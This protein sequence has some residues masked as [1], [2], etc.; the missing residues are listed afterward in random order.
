MCSTGFIPSGV[1][2]IGINFQCGMHGC[3]A[4]KKWTLDAII[5]GA[6]CDSKVLVIKTHSKMNVH[7]HPQRILSE[8]YHKPTLPY[9][10]FKPHLVYKDKRWSQDVS[11][12]GKRVDFSKL[13]KDIVD[14][15]PNHL[16]RLPDCN[17]SSRE[18]DMQDAA[19]TGS[20]TDVP[21]G[22]GMLLGGVGARLVE[23]QLSSS[24]VSMP[25]F[26][27]SRAI[28]ER[29]L[30][31]NSAVENA[32]RPWRNDGDETILEELQ[33]L[34]KFC[35]KEYKVLLTEEMQALYKALD[36]KCHFIQKAGFLDNTGHTYVLLVDM[37]SLMQFL[38]DGS[39]VLLSVRKQ[40][41]RHFAFLFIQLMLI[42]LTSSSTGFNNDGNEYSF[43]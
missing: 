11:N 24:V 43:C 3:F 4:K 21:K 6:D 42:S 8:H 12:V 25:T 41:T 39:G 7:T 9:D 13:P 10:P 30:A 37:A 5:D 18:K 29:S 19:S 26:G 28:R 2:K 14:N 1:A 15:I 33:S 20:R 36:M 22:K 40:E 27:Q 17:L 23:S 34:M 35:N 38:R 16:L 31:P 32:A